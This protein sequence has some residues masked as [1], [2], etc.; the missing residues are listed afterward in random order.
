MET[1]FYSYLKPPK[2]MHK[3]VFLALLSFFRTMR[4]CI[5]CF[6]LCALAGAAYPASAFTAMLQPEHAC[7]PNPTAQSGPEKPVRIMLQWMPQAQFAGYIM[8]LE[9][10]FFAEEGVPNVQLHWTNIGE[11]PLHRVARGEV[12]FATAWLITGLQRRAEGID[13]IN[14]GQFMQHSASLVVARK[15]RNISKVEDLNGKIILT[16]GGDFGIEFEL[17][18]KRNNIVPAKVLPLSDSLAPFLYDLVDATQAM[19]YSEYQ[20]LLER[21]M[22]EDEIVVFPFAQHNVNLVGDGLYTTNAYLQAHGD[23]VR[24][25]R[26]AVER[27]WEYAF[28]HEDETVEAVMRYGDAWQFRS[29]KN[30]QMQMLRIVKRLMHPVGE[31]GD[32]GLLARADFDSAHAIAVEAGLKVAPVTYD[33][34]FKVP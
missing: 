22:K 4:L 12:E 23:L 26:R 34:F 13:I 7:T 5:V 20:R 18:L 10:G 2:A 6:L 29:N 28:A 30:Y 16:W 9:R 25:V 3:S 32:M 14:I 33:N 8:A 1:V 11:S 15:N 31:L 21:G 17:F 19:E 24:G 27:G